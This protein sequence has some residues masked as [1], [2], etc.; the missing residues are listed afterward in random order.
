MEHVKNKQPLRPGSV[1]PF[2]LYQAPLPIN[3]PNVHYRFIIE[4]EDGVWVYTAAG[5]TAVMPLDTTDFQ[6]LAEELRAESYGA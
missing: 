4:A 6:I 3:Q 5:V 2:S 1:Q